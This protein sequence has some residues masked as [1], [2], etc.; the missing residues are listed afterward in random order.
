MGLY[1]SGLTQLTKARIKINQYRTLK[2]NPAICAKA[3]NKLPKTNMID[4]FP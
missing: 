1:G 4:L 3:K 2:I